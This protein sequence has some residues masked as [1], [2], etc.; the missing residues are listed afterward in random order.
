VPASGLS[1][2]DIGKLVELGRGFL[3]R[4]FGYA[5][6]EWFYQ[7]FESTLFIEK[8]VSDDDPVDWR[9]FVVNGAVKLIRVTTN[10][11]TRIGVLKLTYAPDWQLLSVD[12]DT[13]MQPAI[14]KPENLPEMVDLALKVAACAKMNFCRIDLYCIEGQLIVGEVTYTPGDGL[15]QTYNQPW[16]RNMWD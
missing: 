4:R 11:Y 10:F 13:P 15:R 14:P 3:E 16:F 6:G 9:F 2:A 1:E 12:V 5:W 7:T 8:S